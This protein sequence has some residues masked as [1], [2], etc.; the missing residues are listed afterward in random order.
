MLLRTILQDENTVMK[1]Q[2]MILCTDLENS[3][4]QD[5]RPTNFIAKVFHGSNSGFVLIGLRIF[6]VEQI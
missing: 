3:V 6:F 5:I 1:E 4:F 2:I